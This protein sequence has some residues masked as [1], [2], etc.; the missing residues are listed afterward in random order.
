[1]AL[2]NDLIEEFEILC[3]FDLSSRQHGI[4]VHEQTATKTHITATKRLHNKGLV[5]QSDGGYLTPLGLTAAEHAQALLK[6]LN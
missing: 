2:N 3:L 6:L 1:M 4:K 5:E